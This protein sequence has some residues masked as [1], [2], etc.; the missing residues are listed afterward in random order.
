MIPP[1]DFIL[2][3]RSARRVEL[4]RAQGFAFD[5]RPADLPEQPAPGESP[6]DYARRMA[7]A[8][9]RAVL[10]QLPTA[11]LAPVLGSDTDV[12]VDG[13]VLGKPRDRDDALA[14]LMRL[15]DRVHQVYSAVALVTADRETLVC[16]CT[17]VH[18]GRITP[19]DALAYWDSG[20][21]ADKAGA[22]AIQGGAARWVREIR[23][24]YTGVVGLPL[25][26]TVE[27]LAGC[28]IHPRRSRGVAA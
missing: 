22:Y 26:E 11:D 18:F 24:S 2:A 8:K 14:M 20:E 19:Q 3:S 15:S 13:Q 23:G 10:A 17:E 5:C 28:G 21:P 4:L 6:P 12:A 1:P 9:A 16:T 25:H 7:R 27:L